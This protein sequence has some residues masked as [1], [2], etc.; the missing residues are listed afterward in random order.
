MTTSSPRGPSR[1]AYAVAVAS[2]AVAVL[3]RVALTPVMGPVFPLATTFSAVAFVVW[4]GGWA[5]ALFTAIGGFLVTDA[6][7]IP[8]NSLTRP[9]VAEVISIGVYL[10][11]CASIIALGETTRTAQRRLEAGKRELASANLAL[12]SKVE[13][14]SLVAALVASSD[15]AIIS[16]T[17]EGRVTSWNKGAER[18][19]GYT[20]PEAIG[21]SIMMLV[22]P[23][24]HD[25]ELSVRELIRQGQRVDHLDVVRIT[26][27]GQRRNISLSVSPVLDRHGQIIGASKTARDVTI[28]RWPKRGCS[29][30]KPTAPVPS[31]SCARVMT[32]WRWP[33]APANG[34]VVARPGARYRLVESRV[35]GDFW[36]GPGR[37]GLQ[38]APAV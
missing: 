14:Q 3:S 5:P 38:P 6:L 9:P 12:E 10:A 8:G 30:A 32:C 29:A 16:K 4:Y 13:E 23:D 36:N 22:P 21:Q 19:F 28:A 17:L 15:D 33:W 24:Q 2:I 25:Q 1:R 18:L 7:M 31:P 27:S 34:G 11:S 37:S 20:A 26:K 35:R